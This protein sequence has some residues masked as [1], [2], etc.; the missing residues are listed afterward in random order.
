M[1]QIAAILRQDMAMSYRLMR[2]VNAAARGLNHQV[3]S[4]EQA[5]LIMGQAQLDR[6]LTLMML[7]GGLGG[8]GAVLEAALVRAR[9]MELLGQG[10]RGEDTGD[11][12]FV[13]GLFSMLDI[14]LKVPLEEAIRPLNLPTQMREALL[15][16]KG[17]LGNFLALA[18]ASQNGETQRVMQHAVALGLTVRKVNARHIEALT[19]VNAPEVAVAAP[20]F[21][22]SL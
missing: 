14:A 21:E 10:Y 20:N 17:T 9:F 3:S 2:Y 6:W 18:E 7:G 13:L 19:W 22:S 16:Q 5:L 11:R 4:I 1:Q 15:E 8:N 12:L